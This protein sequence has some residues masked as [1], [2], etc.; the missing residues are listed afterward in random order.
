MGQLSAIHISQ[1][2]RYRS[3][4][5]AGIAPDPG[6]MSANFLPSRQ[7]STSPIPLSVGLRASFDHLACLVRLVPHQ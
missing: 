3:E 2:P 5:S 7:G 1:S 6:T 4:S